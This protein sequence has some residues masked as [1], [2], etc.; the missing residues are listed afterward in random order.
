MICDPADYAQ[1]FDAVR[2]GK[3]DDGLRQRL[4]LKAF[5]H[6]ASYDAAI[7]GYLAGVVQP[8]SSFPQ[9]SLCRISGWLPFVTA[10]SAPG[11]ALY[12]PVG[13]PAAYGQLGGK[14]MS[15][16]NWLDMDAAGAR[17]GVRC[18]DGVHHQAHQPL[19][20]GQRGQPGRGVSEWRWP[21][22]RCRPLAA[23]S[24][25]TA[26]PIWRWPAHGGVVRGSRDRA[27]IHRG[28]VGE[29]SPKGQPAS[30]Q[31]TARP[32]PNRR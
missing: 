30:Y 20:R 11:R 23:L 15:Y 28:S 19:R 9:R 16:N 29:V 14:E 25:S 32:K 17:A 8:Y 6:T 31:G 7:A 1:V 3:R 13:Q 22:I 5:Q 10:K 4:A 21:P 27:G 12:I 18:A 24:P 2:A 26:R